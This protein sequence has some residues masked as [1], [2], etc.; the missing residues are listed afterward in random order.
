MGNNFPANQSHLLRAK[1]AVKRLLA[2]ILALLPSVAWGQSTTNLNPRH[3][4]TINAGT[5]TTSQPSLTINQTWNSGATAFNPLRMNITNTTS[6]TTSTLMD[7]KVGG[8]SK[9]SINKDGGWKVTGPF[10]DPMAE[11]LGRYIAMV[12]NGSD[13][14]AFRTNTAVWINGDIPDVDGN[15]PYALNEIPDNTTMLAIGSDVEGPAILCRTYTDGG[16]EHHPLMRGYTWDANI[17]GAQAPRVLDMIPYNFRW[18]NTF[19]SDTSY[20]EF[21]FRWS[22]NILQ[23]GTDKGSAGGTAREMHLYSGGALCIE[24]NTDGSITTASTMTLGGITTLPSGIYFSKPT[25]NQSFLVQANSGGT[26]VDLLYLNASD[27]AVLPNNA[28]VG[29]NANSTLTVYSG[30]AGGLALSGN[31]GTGHTIINSA[32]TVGGNLTIQTRGT[33]C[34][35]F[36]GST[37]T[38]TFAGDAVHSKNVNLS[39]ASTLTVATGV[40]TQTESYHLIA[41]EG[42][43]ADDLVTINGGTEGDI[44]I[45]RASSDSVTITIKDGTG[46]IQC[47]GDRVLDSNQDTFSAVFDGTNWLETGFANNGA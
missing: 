38:A 30:G 26:P 14:P 35:V 2:I 40:V 36:G 13:F 27:V 24:L 33:D 17:G 29:S 11:N 42:A 12:G 22:G 18:Y 25:N 34:V 21:F 31:I 32:N 19:T 10:R 9:F 1:D 46:N 3:P 45:I 37:Q 8:I 7:L 41:G 16:G 44:L 43:A 23:M 6:A 28:Q 4:A 15:P 47:G 39:A 5:L 20:E